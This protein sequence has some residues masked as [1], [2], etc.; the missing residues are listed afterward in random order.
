MGVKPGEKGGWKVDVRPEGREGPRLRRTFQRKLDAD[1]WYLKQKVAGGE[2][3]WT[4]PNK[5]TRK[6]TDI[7]DHWYKYH[8]HTLATGE[9]RL[10][11]L[12][13]TCKALGNPIARNVDPKDFLDYREKRLRK[14]TTANHLNHELTYLK[15]AFNEL[16][17]IDDWRQANP[18]GKLKKLNFD[19]A[20]LTFLTLPE[21]QKLLDALAEARNPHVLMITKIC[22]ST[23]CRWG[24][25]EGLRGEQIH[26]GQVHYTGTKN[27]KNRSVPITPELEK[28][29]FKDRPRRGPLFGGSTEAFDL[30][31]ER[32]GI[33]LPKGQKTHVLRHSFASHFM[34][35]GGN[36]LDLNKI[37]GHKTI[38]MTMVYAHLS[39]EHLVKAREYNP[40]KQLE[41]KPAQPLPPSESVHTESTQTTENEDV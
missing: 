16:I 14:G 18:F 4:A 36:L 38:Q 40:L 2:G 35:N 30:G 9:K 27:R 12:K 26:H 22:L 1:Q 37:L 25:A 32:A 31:L 3:T 41:A 15:S 20:E 19:D 11:I 33:E 7:A 39:P 29:I 6:L 34:M 8:G 28:E 13:A 24:E 17:R 10:Q 21:I 23:G 5:D